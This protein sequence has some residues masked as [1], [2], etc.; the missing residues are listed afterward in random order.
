MEEHSALCRFPR[1]KN[2]LKPCKTAFFGESCSE[3]EVRLFQ[4][5]PGFEISSNFQTILMQKDSFRI[6]IKK[7]HKRLSQTSVLGQAHN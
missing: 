3:T 7:N 1:K 2:R 4:N 6:T 5:Q